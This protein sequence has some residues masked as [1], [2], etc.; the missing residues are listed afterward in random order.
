MRWERVLLIPIILVIVLSLTNHGV[1]AQAQPNQYYGENGGEI[2]GYV[3]SVSGPVDWAAIYANNGQNRYEAFSG[4]SGF[5]EMRVPAAKYNVTV[6]VQG[7]EALASNATVLN[8]STT[9]VNFNLN[10]VTVAV[11]GGSSSVINFYL[12]QNQ[13]PVPEFQPSLS[14]ALITS[15]FAALVVLRR[16]FRDRE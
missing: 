16:S 9:N 11:S 13:T 3:L 2:S 5:Y 10:S 1:S 6:V 12:Q 15:M 8:G 14:L 7:Y 4:M